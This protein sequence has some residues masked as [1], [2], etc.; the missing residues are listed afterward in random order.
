M[1]HWTGP[2]AASQITLFEGKMAELHTLSGK[3]QDPGQDFQVSDKDGMDYDTC[4]AGCCRDVEPAHR[5][6]GHVGSEEHPLTS[7]YSSPCGLPWMRYSS[8]Q[9]KRVEERGQDAQ[10]FASGSAQRNRFVSVPS[11]RFQ[12]NYGKIDWSK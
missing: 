1:R 6:G 3:P 8:E 10:R 5:T 4:P 9:T 12:N 11:K 2:P 7:I